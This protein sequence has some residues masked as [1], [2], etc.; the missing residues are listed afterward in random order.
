MQSV[1]KGFCREAEPIEYAAYTT[2]THTHTNI[3]THAHT[4]TNVYTHAHTY[5]HAHIHMHIHTYVHTGTY[6]Y[7]CT[8]QLG[9]HTCNPSYSGGRDQEALSSKPAPENSS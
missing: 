6:I 3:Y 8:L 4:Y 9:A 2:H 1:S 5:I 7:T